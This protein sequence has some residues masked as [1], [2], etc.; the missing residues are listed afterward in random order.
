MYY[1]KILTYTAAFFMSM[2]A[3]SVFAHHPSATVVDADTFA[4]ITENLEA[5]DSPHLT[6]DLDSMG[7]A[8]A[9]S[10]SAMDQAATLQAGPVAD[11]TGVIID[12]DAPMDAATAANTMDLLENVAE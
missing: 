7:S 9:M 5:A 10:S 11:Q 6:M 12:V 2:A 3:T 4:M 8:A 1:M